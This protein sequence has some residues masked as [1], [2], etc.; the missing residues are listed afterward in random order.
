MSLTIVFRDARDRLASL[1]LQL[2]YFDAV[3]THEPKNAPG[4]G[5]G[6]FIFCDGY[7]PVGTSGLNSTSVRMVI[8][9]QI[10]VSMTREPEDDID[11]DMLEAADALCAEVSGDFDLG[12]G[13][14]AV[15]L[16]GQH[17]PGL[18]GQFGY[19][20]QGDTLYRVIDISIPCIIN[21]VWTQGA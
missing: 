14:R 6:L 11:L 13:V 8:N 12:A 15:D 21:D 18:G 17:G 7:F 16:L 5:L 4:K 19:L 3:R 9:A 20:R 1:G 2:G 10:R